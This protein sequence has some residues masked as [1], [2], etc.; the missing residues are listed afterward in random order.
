M[1]RNGLA[2]AVS[3]RQEPPRLVDLEDANGAPE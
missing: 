3:L 2:F 1:S